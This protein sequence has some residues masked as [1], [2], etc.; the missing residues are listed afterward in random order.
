MAQVRRKEIECQV[1][2]P[3]H[4]DAVFDF[5]F[6]T[7][8]FHGNFFALFESF[9]QPGNSDNSICLGQ[10]GEDASASGEWSRNERGTDFSQ[11]DAYEFVD[12]EF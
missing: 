6:I 4:D 5:L 10:G 8:Q 1:V 9:R 3:Y 12:S 11:R 2:T 7:K